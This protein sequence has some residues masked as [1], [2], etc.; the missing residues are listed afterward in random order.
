[1]N[2][3]T[4]PESQHRSPQPAVL[5]AILL[6]TS[7]FGGLVAAEPPLVRVVIR[8]DDWWATPAQSPTKARVDLRVLEI[9]VK[10]GVPITIAYVPAQSVKQ[11]DGKLTFAVLQRDDPVLE[12]L[13]RAVASHGVEVALHGL[14]HIG[15]RIAG[16][17][18]DEFVSLEQAYGAKGVI[19]SEF[20]GRPAEEQDKMIAEGQRILV[21]AGLPRPVTFVPPF[22]GYDVATCTACAR[23]GLTILSADRRGP[24]PAPSDSVRL[25]PTSWGWNQQMAHLDELVDFA[26][27][28]GGQRA[29]SVVLMHYFDFEESGS[30]RAVTTLAKFD[31]ELGRVARHPA[32]EVTTLARLAADSAGEATAAR[33]E[34]DQRFRNGMFWLHNVRL[35]PYRFFPDPH[36]FWA[37]WPTDFYAPLNRWVL[38]LQAATLGLLALGGCAIG[39]GVGAAWR[40]RPTVACV[41][42]VAAVAA[43]G[44]YAFTRRM[45]SGAVMTAIVAGLLLAVV[46]RLGWR[47]L[48][49]GGGGRHV[50]N[51]AASQENTPG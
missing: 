43:S 7:L 37:Y 34:A 12:P 2:V 6:V 20:T 8:Y 38:L 22:N 33:Y 46:V 31:E 47:V 14:H 9:A 39:L 50:G 17:G 24:L 44:A 41:G 11:P 30:G 5:A 29:V 18:P 48:S 49:R 26:R 1:M 4:T 27:R 23:H 35:L 16:E 19:Y 40:W 45:G 32:I 21:E 36:Y 15:R 51:E 42:L 28:R 25:F 3:L 10:H 13:R